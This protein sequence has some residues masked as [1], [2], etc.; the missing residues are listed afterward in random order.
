MIVYVMIAALFMLIVITAV[1]S[2][3]IT[4]DKRN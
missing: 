4:K 1:S 2:L 3:D